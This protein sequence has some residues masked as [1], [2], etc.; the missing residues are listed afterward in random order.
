MPNLLEKTAVQMPLLLIG[1]RPSWMLDFIFPRKQSTK[2]KEAV[3]SFWT[4]IYSAIN[5][6]NF[7]YD[8]T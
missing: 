7:D 3:S 2:F 8:N 4:L 1:R 5:Q 6:Y